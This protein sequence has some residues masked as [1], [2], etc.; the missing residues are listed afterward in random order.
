MGMVADFGPWVR[1]SR[2]FQRPPKKRFT[3]EMKR[4]MKLPLLYADLRERG[5]LP[6]F[7]F[8]MHSTH[9]Q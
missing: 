2:A 6:F 9:V 8:S 1:K 7:R 5:F 3:R 4:S